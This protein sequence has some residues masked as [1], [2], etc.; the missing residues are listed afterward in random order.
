MPLASARAPISGLLDIAGGV[1]ILLGYHAKVGAW[2]IALFLVPVTFM[3]H[4]FWTVT[5]PVME[6]VQMI[7]FMKNAAMLGGA[8][9]IPQFGAG[10]LS[11]NTR[12]SR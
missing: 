10:P 11:L 1:N 7:M 2:L 9:L 6:Q 5:D 12:R 3:M 4:K 8:L